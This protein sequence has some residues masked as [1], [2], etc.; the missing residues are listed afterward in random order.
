LFTQCDEPVTSLTS[1]QQLLQSPTFQEQTMAALAPSLRLHCPSP[2]D[3]D[4]PKR[5][6]RAGPNPH[7]DPPPLE[8][9]GEPD[10]R[11]EPDEFEVPCTDDAPWEVF[12]ADDDDDPLPEPGDF[13]IDDPDE[14]LGY[15]RP[16]DQGDG[17][18]R[19]TNDD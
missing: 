14:S 9:P 5:R 16:D 11:A 13:W 15:C 10:E 8:P 19:T 2:T 18:W 4:L 6:R 17:G 1:E 3:S 7:D 12:I